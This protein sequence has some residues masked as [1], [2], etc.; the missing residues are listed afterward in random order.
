[1]VGRALL[2]IQKWRE[3]KKQILMFLQHSQTCRKSAQV[4]AFENLWDESYLDLLTQ[5][6]QL[7]QL[8]CDVPQSCCWDRSWIIIV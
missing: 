2:L 1:M 8:L 3:C 6:I 4:L 7:Q 5:T